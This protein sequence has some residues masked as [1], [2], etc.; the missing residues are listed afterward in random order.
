MSCT[1]VA[2][3]MEGVT[4]PPHREFVLESPEIQVMQALFTASGVKRSHADLTSAL[5]DMIKQVT[6]SKL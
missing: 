5:N 3:M 4:A 1:D 6:K 2:V